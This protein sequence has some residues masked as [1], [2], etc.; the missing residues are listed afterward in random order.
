MPMSFNKSLKL[1]AQLSVRVTLWGVGDGV[2]TF[3]VG[4]GTGVGMGVGDVVP[5]LL[6]SAWPT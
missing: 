1:L 5:K 2:G 6:L 3:V 4:V